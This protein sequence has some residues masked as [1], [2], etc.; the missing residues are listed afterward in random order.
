MNHLIDSAKG[1][2]KLCLLHL[3]HPSAINP[4]QVTTAIND[5]LDRLNLIAAKHQL[6]D[7]YSAVRAVMPSHLRIAVAPSMNH[8]APHQ[9]IDVFVFDGDDLID[10]YTGRTPA[11]IAE[12]LRLKFLEAA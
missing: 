1:A 12:L 8:I 9:P 6:E 7:T 5:A 11:G 3:Q 2:L 4:T 10:V